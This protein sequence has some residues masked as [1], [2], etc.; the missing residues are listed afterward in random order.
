MGYYK[1]KIR[2]IGRIFVGL[3]D[4]KERS[5]AYRNRTPKPSTFSGYTNNQRKWKAPIT[6]RKLDFLSCSLVWLYQSTNPTPFYLLYTI[7]SILAQI[8]IVSIENMLLRKMA[9]SSHFSYGEKILS[10]AF[11]MPS[12]SPL[13]LEGGDRIF[14][15]LL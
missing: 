10:T 13:L 9:N 3:K 1:T 4:K 7:R 15:H 8:K 6:L 5:K 12:P 11:K 2:P 14:K